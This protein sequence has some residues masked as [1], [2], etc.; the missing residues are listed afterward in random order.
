MA[1]EE[2][3][4]PELLPGGPD[5]HDRAAPPA[6]EPERRARPDLLPEHR[7]RT[8]RPPTERKLHDPAAPPPA[9]REHHDRAAR[10]PASPGRRERP[11]L[12][13]VGHED[14]YRAGL[15]AGGEG[16]RDRAALLLA[17][18]RRVLPDAHREWGR[19][20]A[21][22]LASIADPT[23]RW[24]FARGCVWAA[25]AEF[26]LGRAAGHLAA[27]LGTLAAL[28]AW[29]GAVGSPAPA[30]ILYL[31]VPVLAAV[32]WRARQL[33]L[34]GPT[35][36]GVG[37]GL[38]R[39]AGYLIAAGLVVTAV[40]HTHPATL[41]ATD[42]GTGVLLMST[43]AASFLIG[44]VSVLGR[45]SPA[46]ARVLVTGTGSGVAATAAWLTVMV[47]APPIPPSIGWALTLTAAAAVAA[48][49]ANARPADT[50]VRCLLAGLI[51]ITTTMVLIFFAVVALSRWG[52]DRLIPAI[53][54]HALPAD[55]VE[56]S[57]IEIVDPYVVVLVLGAVA[58]AAASAT[59][60]FGRRRI[61]RAGS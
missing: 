25:A 12:L 18:V 49:L 15:V 31:T 56:N 59:A 45:R 30:A 46:T 39:G 41:E 9:K 37:A 19:A 3:G 54:P 8:A 17:G 26:H 50:P 23:E 6:T 61:S 44:L 28:L 20:M 11:E 40:R 29:V 48:V 21:A 36:D 38:L 13:P 47:V 7:D 22:E 2:R 1:P 24:G 14:R 51:A 55:R 10:P 52:P 27:V 35:G 60:V 4:R 5:H 43:V 16:R 42:Q 33:G 53:A 57:R 34:F 32:C 58:A